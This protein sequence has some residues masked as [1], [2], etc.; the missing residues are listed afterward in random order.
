MLDKN[1]ANTLKSVHIVFKNL[2]CN[3]YCNCSILDSLADLVPIRP[4]LPQSHFRKDAQTVQ[5]LG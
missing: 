2:E 1:T 4:F 3:V 5:N